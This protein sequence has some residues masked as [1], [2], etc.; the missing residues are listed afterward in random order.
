MF[1][2]AYR[3]LSVG[4]RPSLLSRNCGLRG[5]GRLADPLES[6]ERFSKY[7]DRSLILNV[8]KMILV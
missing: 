5:L 7:L 2:E 6:S 1:S 8:G 3:S 4:S